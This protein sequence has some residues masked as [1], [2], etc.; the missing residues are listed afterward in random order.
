MD[1][2]LYFAEIKYLCLFYV[3]V[4]DIQQICTVLNIDRFVSEIQVLCLSMKVL[5]S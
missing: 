5:N 3:S 2:C 4:A 1:V